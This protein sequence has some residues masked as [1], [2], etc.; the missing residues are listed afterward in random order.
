MSALAPYW[1]FH[2]PNFLLAALMYTVIGRLL[3]SFFAPPDW[4]NY[5]W[6]AFVRLTEPVVKAVRAVT[7]SLLPDPVVLVFTAFWLMLARLAL[8][9]G[10]GTIGLLPGASGPS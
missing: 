3:L 9:V 5:I 6:R 10:L 8:F 4:R 1:Y 2:L 7:P